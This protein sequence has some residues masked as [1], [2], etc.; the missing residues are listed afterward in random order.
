MESKDTTIA[1]KLNS[2]GSY[3]FATSGSPGMNI[4]SYSVIR[5]WN[6][7]IQ[8]VAHLGGYGLH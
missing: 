3:G 8:L 7:L 2:I 5:V 6:G 4:G 1:W